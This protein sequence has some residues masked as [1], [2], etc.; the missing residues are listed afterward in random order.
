MGPSGSKGSDF[1][2]SRLSSTHSNGCPPA[3]SWLNFGYIRLLSLSMAAM[4]LFVTI[5][6]TKPTRLCRNDAAA[7]K[8]KFACCMRA[9]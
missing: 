2:F 9:L 7:E 4:I 5:R 8:L 3:L 6:S 1:D